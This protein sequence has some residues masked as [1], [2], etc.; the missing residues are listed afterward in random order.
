MT[1]AWCFSAVIK[2]S[3]HL[4][5]LH[6]WINPMNDKTMMHNAFFMGKNGVRGNKI[7][8]MGGIWCLLEWC[9]CSGSKLSWWSNGTVHGERQDWRLWTER[10]HSPCTLLHVIIQLPVLCQFQ[11][12]L[13]K[14][15]LGVVSSPTPSIMFFK[16]SG[17]FLPAADQQMPILS[18]SFCA[19]LIYFSKF[20]N[21]H[22]LTVKLHTPCIIA[23]LSPSL[24]H[25]FL[26]TLSASFSSHTHTKNAPVLIKERVPMT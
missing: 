5:W 14:G 11:A 15:K 19:G 1:H 3:H 8:N 13:I 17:Y 22:L 18:S 7:Q 10:A 26:T 20:S 6:S 16:C 4:W 2:K 12:C 23:W 24:Y 21:Y 9:H 25:H